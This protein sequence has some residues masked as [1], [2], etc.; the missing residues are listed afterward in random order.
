[1]VTGEV[2]KEVPVCGDRSE[3]DL[4]VV[5]SMG[6]KVNIP[7][8]VRTMALCFRFPIASRLVGPRCAASLCGR[9]GKTFLKNRF[10]GGPKYRE[11]S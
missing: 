6:E 8:D 10:G 5:D 4:T 2:P 7:I 11:L 1:V 9:F 3:T